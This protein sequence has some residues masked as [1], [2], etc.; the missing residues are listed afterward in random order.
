LNDQKVQEAIAIAEAE[1]SKHPENEFYRLLKRDDLL[2]HFKRL[3]KW[4]NRFY[5][6]ANKKIYIKSICIELNKIS[7]NPDNWYLD[8]FAYDNFGGSENYKW[9]EEWQHENPDKDSFKI[10]GLEDIQDVFKKLKENDEDDDLQDQL[11]I[12][13]QEIVLLRLFEL[14]D[15]AFQIGREKEKRWTTIPVIV[16]ADGNDLIYL[17]SQ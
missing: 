5:K 11:I 13:A 10:K 1:L 12:I 14:F 9:L 6:A 7:E 4:L 17:I 16:K 8:G 15:S 2:K 3:Y